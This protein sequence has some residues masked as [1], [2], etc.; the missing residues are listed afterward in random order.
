MC[1]MQT[2]L[3]IQSKE[4]GCITVTVLY[5]LNNTVKNFSSQPKNI[6]AQFF[7]GFFSSI[8]AQF[9]LIFSAIFGQILRKFCIFFPAI[10][11]RDCYIQSSLFTSTC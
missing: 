4:L 10:F 5:F 7:R 3:I 8:C 1:F 9:S 2:L 6:Y 11:C